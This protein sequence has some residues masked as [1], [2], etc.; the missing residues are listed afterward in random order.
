MTAKR[1][2]GAHTPEPN[3]ELSCTSPSGAARLRAGTTT[4]P[5]RFVAPSSPWRRARASLVFAALAAT[6]AS[7][8]TPGCESAQATG[9][10]GATTGSSSAAGATAAAPT[11]SSHI[12]QAML[13]DRMLVG[14]TAAR[15]LGYRIAWESTTIVGPGNTFSR[16]NVS[17][18][19]AFVL[20]SDNLLARIKL[21]DGTRVWQT[22]VGQQSDR[23]LG[24]A[25]IGDRLYL[26]AEGGM[27]VVDAANG[28]QIDRQRFDRPAS[29]EAIPVPPYLVYGGRT[30]EIVWL[31]YRVGYP[32]RVNAVDGSIRVAPILLDNDVVAV[33]TAGSV[34]V[35]DARTA[36]TIWTKQLLDGI[37]AR[38]AGGNGVIFIASKDQY[39]WALAQA[40]GRTL[41]KH[42][43]DA[44]LTTPPF[45]LDDR[46]YQR[47]PN[48][49][50]CCFD[51]FVKNQP[52]G[53]I[54]WINKSVVGEVIGRNR[55]NLLVWDPASHTL[56]T[57]DSN[58]AT[59]QTLQ[60]P[61]VDHI[62]PTKPDGGDLFAASRDGRVERLVPQ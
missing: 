16:V 26:T 41:W 59:I 49:G 27:I 3:L 20:D 57:V 2:L 33:S 54:L 42:F 7:L 23:C 56:S 15:Q 30:G 48:T 44:S 21:E 24:I 8:S 40:D 32:W 35:M 37:E 39:L 28:T 4:S 29:T 61:Q 25:R 46:L 55:G 43:N 17:D 9:A 13:D 38:P 53:K 1:P 47:L 18:D 22:P 14:P 5:R 11:E 62:R 58:G 60:L 31:E 10:D 45:L 51:A 19:A 12:A 6:L 50:L 34:I 36:R 52:D